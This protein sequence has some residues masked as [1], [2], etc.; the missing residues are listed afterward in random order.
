VVMQNRSRGMTTKNERKFQDALSAIAPV[1]GFRLI[2][3]LRERVVYRE[4]FPI[5]LTLFDLE[6][7]PKLGRRQPGARDEIASMLEALNLPSEALSTRA[8][9]VEKQS[10]Q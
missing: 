1:A 3:G 7:I 5:G 9:A 6:Q 8:A 2:P 10:I 4:L